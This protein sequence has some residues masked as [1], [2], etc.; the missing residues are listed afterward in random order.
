MSAKFDEQ[1]QQYI[2]NDYHNKK[3]FASF[4]PGIAGKYGV[5]MWTYYVN[6]GQLI[7]S[8]G[9][10]NKDKAI[11]DF[12]PANLAYRRTEIDGFRTFVKTDRGSYEVFRNKDYAHR[13]MI[14][15]K[16]MVG[17]IEE[18]DELIVSVKYFNVAN[19]PYAGLVRKVVIKAKKD[20]QISFLD[21]LATIWPFGT[22]NYVTKNMSNLGVAWFD[23]FNEENKAP[24]FK[25]RSTT[26]DS[27]EVEQIEN[28]N[29]Y[30][31]VDNKNSLLKP[32]YDSNVV[33]GYDLSLENPKGFYESEYQTFISRPQFKNNQ[34]LMGFSTGSIKLK[35]EEEYCFYT[36]FGSTDNLNG[37]KD[38][39]NNTSFDDFK[40]MEI[41]ATKLVNELTAPMSV[42]SN[43]P[44]FDAYLK[45]A[46]LDNI[47]RGGYPYVFE[48]K[49][50]AHVYH[51]FSRI[52]G[53]ME[54]EYNN[55]NV[56]PT[57]YSQGNGSYRD[58]NQ[59]RRNDVYF[60]KEAGYYNIIQFMELIQYDGRNPLTIKGSKF[61]LEDNI[62]LILS[63]VINKKEQFENRL[64]D[65]FSLGSLLKFIEINGITLTIDKEQFLEL[66]LKNSKQYPDA[67]FGTGYW[68][69]H[70]IYN[71][72]LVETYLNIF[73]DKIKE[74]LFDSKVRFYQSHMSVYER[75]YRYVL[76]KNN[77]VR[78][79]G[80]LYNDYEK[81]E[82][83]GLIKE[84]TNF[85]KDDQGEIVTV[86]LFVKYL[87]LA[88]VKYMNLDQEKMGIMMDADKPGW[89][90]AMNGLPA[91]FGSGLTET[92]ALYKLI[93]YLLQW[94]N[95][96]PDTIITIPFDFSN[97]LSIL[98]NN[99]DK[100]FDTIQDI[101]ESFLEE[102]RI[103][104][105]HKNV[106][107]NLGNLSSLLEKLLLVIKTGLEKAKELG[108]GLIPTYLSYKALEYKKTGLLNPEISYEAVEVTKWQVRAL[109]LFLEAPAV[110]LKNIANKD[111][112]KLIYE[113]IRN[114]EMYDDKLNLYITSKS[115]DDEN[116][117]I[118][119]ARAFTKGWLER[120][121]C[122]M[123]MNF[124]YLVGLLKS[125]LY[126]EYYL[127]IKNQ[128]PAF[129]DFNVY[130]RSV[131]E[132]V[133]FIA[134]S[135]NPNPN[136][137][138]RGYVAR[139]T[140]TTSEAITL[141]YLM[142]LGS[143]PFRY[144]DGQLE[145]VVSPKLA[146]DFFVNNEVSFMFLE[147]INIVIFNPKGIDTFALQATKYVLSNDK[148]KIVVDDNSL[149]GD[150][151][152]DIRKKRFTRI[153]VILD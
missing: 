8:F 4:L 109:P 135:N 13:E 11:L 67:I 37:L 62:E 73:P 44:V 48:G 29:F 10:E 136:Q 138:G 59:N 82:K 108:N 126:D 25:N 145:F 124:K 95:E 40:D 34:L 153:E 100:D 22:S 31:T 23:V 139:L 1:K 132:N 49:D 144:D 94:T 61:K 30:F 118:G 85:H 42:K 12:S 114:T 84:Q 117:D 55:F 63:K 111:E 112:A 120:E 92:I 105:N 51:T 101:R 141:F 122:F 65:F 74:L 27:A 39:V 15:E 113:V 56:E 52:H 50:S 18:N 66:V 64:N 17:I 123:H 116:L 86:N 149:K 147:S 150:L 6:R 121:S 88:I 98:V 76:N 102:S 140:G 53:D 80:V 93:K 14:I 43:Y 32:I 131:L 146:K 87:H 148:E 78:Q 19:R 96:F 16:N 91:I 71:L 79:L 133:S 104:I 129:M 54:R 152:T 130:G 72:D 142:F 75:K 2:I 46:F 97:L 125:G 60:V 21:G 33:F 45:Q 3:P 83:T 99:Y 24:F 127:E 28:G 110:Y 106:K 57:Y 128:M 151:A 70:W 77:Q 68:S 58:V 26:E 38:L 115:L 103:F 5:P 7:S 69:D 41:E 134:T 89:N 9:I 143:K 119:R 81:M 90:D 107:V 137:R 20:N 35:G 47:L 36:L